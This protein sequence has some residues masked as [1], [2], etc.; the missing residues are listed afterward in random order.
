MVA[1]DT[2]E[3]RVN[4]Y[5]LK[6][7]ADPR[8]LPVMEQARFEN[9]KRSEE[10]MKQLRKQIIRQRRGNVPDTVIEEVTNSEMSR[11]YYNKNFQG[12]QMKCF[13]DDRPLSESE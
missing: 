10:A 8:S 4:K 5:V 6:A 11:P 12:E 7:M 3:G 2:K 1:K 9:M 13:D